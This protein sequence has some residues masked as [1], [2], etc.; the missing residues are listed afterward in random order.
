MEHAPKR[1]A[2]IP[3]MTFL[4]KRLSIVRSILV[5]LS[6]LGILLGNASVAFAGFGITPPYVNN[7]RLTR[8][9]SFTQRI[10]LVRSDPTE[11]LTA[12]ITMNIP[13]A[14]A[15]IS[16][17]RGMEFTMPAGVTDVPIVVT[18]NVPANAE[19]KSYTGAIRVRT[20]TTNAPVGGGVSIALGAQIDVN[21]KVVDKIYDFNVRQI[22]V[23]DLEEGRTKWGLFFPGKI[24]FYMTIENTGNTVF[25][26]TKVHFDI[27]D[28][29]QENLLESVDNTNNI[30]QIAPFAIKEVEADLP[31]RLPPG[32]YV[33]KYT[34]YKNGDIAQQN[35]LNLSVAAIGA[36]AGY[37][38]YGFDGL[39]LVDKLKVVAAIGVPL[40]LLILIIAMLVSRRNRRKRKQSNVVRTR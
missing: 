15:W 1:Y 13:G 3:T 24:R 22:R 19:Y 39:S 4:L 33:A 30:E 8:G 12:N 2:I 31:T 6:V 32:S 28:S 40:I 25:G 18:V 36:V 27:Y 17:D 10:D 16:I 7:Q 14:E 38:G 11:D 21:L 23:A 20:S 29:N 5:S 34:I 26:P 37:T 35:T 9:T